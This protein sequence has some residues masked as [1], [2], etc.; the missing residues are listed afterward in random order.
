MGKRKKRLCPAHGEPHDGTP[1]PPTKPSTGPAKARRSVG[2]Q[3]SEHR[4]FEVDVWASENSVE[5]YRDNVRVAFH[6][7]AKHHGKFITNKGHYPDGK[8][9]YIEST[10]T[11]LQGK[12]ARMGTEISDLINEILAEPHPLKHLRRAQ[13]ILRLEQKYDRLRLG[14]AITQ[15]KLHSSSISCQTLEKLLKLERLDLTAKRNLTRTQ[16][17]DL[18]QLGFD[19]KPYERKIRHFLDAHGNQSAW[20]MYRRYAYA[21]LDHG[22]ENEDDEEAQKRS[23]EAW[24]KYVLR[25]NLRFP[26]KKIAA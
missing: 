26:D 10:P 21:M 19:S 25:F 15:A 11:Y 16:V 5:I 4:G 7:R 20:D 2:S 12:A 13:G 3:S 23:R 8:K 22:R 14:R 1:P 17:N 18:F 6:P 24:Q 9:A